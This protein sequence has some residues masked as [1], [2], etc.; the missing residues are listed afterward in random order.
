MIVEQIAFMNVIK[1]F[2]WVWEPRK[3]KK[4]LS[5]KRFVKVDLVEKC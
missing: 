2:S 3:I 4:I 1:D 5:M